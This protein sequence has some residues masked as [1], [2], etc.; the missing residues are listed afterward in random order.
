MQSTYRGIFIDSY[1][2]SFDSEEPQHTTMTFFTTRCELD[3]YGCHNKTSWERDPK[4]LQKTLSP[5]EVLE[6]VVFSREV[7]GVD[8]ISLSG[9]ECTLEQ[10]DVVFY[11]K[12]FYDEGLKVRIETNGQH[13]VSLF[14]IL[15]NSPVHKVVMDIKISPSM[16]PVKALNILKGRKTRFEEN[17]ENIE[18]G[19]KLKEI[20]F[21]RLERSYLFCLRCFCPVSFRTVKYP[22]LEENEI[23]EIEEWCKQR[24]VPWKLNNFIE[25]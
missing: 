6:K 19:L 2:I 22:L 9:G 15:E 8:M 17:E 5:K 23:S 24:K 16:N 1:P 12:M 25:V 21:K 20:Y 3:C 11:S 4:I 10:E 18:K 13:P 7:L 14:Y